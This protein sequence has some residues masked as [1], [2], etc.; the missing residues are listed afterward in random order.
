MSTKIRLSRAGRRN[1]PFYHVVVADDR[2]PRDGKFIE[3]IGYYDP[4]LNEESERRFKLN[5][6]RAEYW[7]SVGAIPTDRIIVLFKGVGVG[8]AE[9][10]K[11]KIKNTVTKNKKKK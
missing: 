2:A 8:G 7:L 10:F 1:L 6:E 9:K 11:P 3:K 4:I 5:R